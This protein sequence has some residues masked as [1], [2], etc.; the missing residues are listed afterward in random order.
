MIH[1]D[2]VSKTF[3]KNTEAS[4]DNV[5]VSIAKGEFVTLIGHSGSGK[6][7]FM[8]L[9]LGEEQP[10]EGAVHFDGTNVSKISKS[11]LP[12]HRR[13]IGVVFQDF[14]LL[15]KMT[16]FENIAFAMEAS[17]KSADEIAVDVPYIFELVNLKGKEHRFPHELSGGEQQR[18]SIA[19]ALINRPD[20][21]LADEPTGN[22]DPRATDEVVEILRKINS[23]GTT[24]IMATHDL[25]VIEKAKGRVIE[26]NNGVIISDKKK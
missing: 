12:R 7:T 19:R 17:G 4:L 11:H 15:K 5:T 23:L 24:V 25:P 18:V 2:R 1:F 20:L 3:K 10:S 13:K 9:I 16:S 14:K 6:T 21:I 8:K 22:L 26:F